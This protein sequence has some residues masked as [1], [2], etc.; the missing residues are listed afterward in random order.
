MV[1]G[2]GVHVIRMPDHAGFLSPI[3]HTVPLQLLAYHAALE[4][5]NDVDKRAISPNRSPWNESA[6]PVPKRDR[7]IA[8][9]D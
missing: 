6:R 2:E 9:P 1:A 4:R 8:R 3:L 5:G 7:L